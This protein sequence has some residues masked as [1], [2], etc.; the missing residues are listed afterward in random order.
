[1]VRARLTVIVRR[2]ELSARKYKY[3]DRVRQVFAIKRIILLVYNISQKSVPHFFPMEEVYQTEIEDTDVGESDTETLTEETI[4]DFYF[5]ND[6]LQPELNFT[7][8]CIAIPSTNECVSQDRLLRKT[9][10]PPETLFSSSTRP[11]LNFTLDCIA[12]PSTNECVSQDRLLRNTVS[13][14]E[15]I[16]TSLCWPLLIIPEIPVFDEQ[17]CLSVVLPSLKP[18]REVCTIPTMQLNILFWDLYTIPSEPSTPTQQTGG[19]D[20][21]N[22]IAPINNLMPLGS[23]SSYQGVLNSSTSLPFL[24]SPILTDNDYQFFSEL[25]QVN[26]ADSDDLLSDSPPCDVN[27][28]SYNN[29]ASDSND[30]VDFDQ[31]QAMV[32]DNYNENSY[33][34]NQ[35]VEYDADYDDEA[36]HPE[37][38]VITDYKRK[39]EYKLDSSKRFRPKSYGKNKRTEPE[40]FSGDEYNM[41]DTYQSLPSIFSD[42]YVAIAQSSRLPKTNSK[43]SS[44]CF[45]CSVKG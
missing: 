18:N 33:F 5:A 26:A 16:F 34:Q 36:A 45:F 17:C 8:D 4:D 19:A 23:S 2:K 42:A 1:M 13:P 9:V 12:I 20:E 43:N 24:A 29:D 3:S 15:T 11:E 32:D 35:S 39:A 37:T 21:Y 28:N 38:S 25:L 22:L 14:P 30:V 27:T 31:T 44:A 40:P 7:L 10:S 41:F 6:L